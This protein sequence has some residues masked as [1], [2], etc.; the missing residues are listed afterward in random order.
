MAAAATGLAP[1]ALTSRLAWMRLPGN[2]WFLTLTAVASGAALI[3][4]LSGSSRLTSALTWRPLCALGK[5]SYGV[6]LYYTLGYFL[7]STVYKVSVFLPLPGTR[8]GNWDMLA[9]NAMQMILTVVMAAA[10]YRY[11]ERPL[12]ALKERF[13]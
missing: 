9:I 6:Y 2:A 11:L 10:S 12:L 4:A 3:L 13:R 1:Y 8:I 5:I 7:A